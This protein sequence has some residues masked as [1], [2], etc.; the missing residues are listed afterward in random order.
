MLQL[1]ARKQKAIVT[2][3][4]LSPHYA[5]CDPW[6]SKDKNRAPLHPDL[7]IQN[8]PFPKH[9]RC[10]ST[11]PVTVPEQR[12]FVTDHFPVPRV[13]HRHTAL[14]IS[15][16]LMHLTCACPRDSQSLVEEVP[17]KMRVCGE[18]CATPSQKH[19]FLAGSVVI[20]TCILGS[21]RK[22]LSEMVPRLSWLPAT[23]EAPAREM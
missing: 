22:G 7:L 4:P 12:C 14:L 23:Q 1:R 2:G 20:V 11:R 13:T 18:L 5:K 21:T 3:G 6:T 10:C 16:P 9:P 15:I 19:L 8:L 17:P